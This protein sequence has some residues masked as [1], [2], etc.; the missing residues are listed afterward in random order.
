MSLH[1]QS[2]MQWL[3]RFVDDSE[4]LLHTESIVSNH[5]LDSHR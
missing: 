3:H 4:G 5:T 2:A 1:Q